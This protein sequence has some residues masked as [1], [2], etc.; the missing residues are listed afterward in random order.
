MLNKNS[1]NIDLVPPQEITKEIKD[2]VSAKKAT[3][4]NL[5][6]GEIL[7]QLSRKGI[8]FLTNKHD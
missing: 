5:V 6:T 2:N 7:K 3:D 4:V 8:V 1:L